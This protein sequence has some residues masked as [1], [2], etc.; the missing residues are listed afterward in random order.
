MLIRFPVLAFWPTLILHWWWELITLL[1]FM[2]TRTLSEA[3]IDLTLADSFPASDP[4]AWTLGRE[5]QLGLSADF[6]SPIEAPNNE[7]ATPISSAVE[8]RGIKRSKGAAGERNNRR[9]LLAPK[10]YVVPKTNNH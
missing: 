5:V 2:T 7:P 9:Q 1:M 4:P 6:A 3:L 8:R 10:S